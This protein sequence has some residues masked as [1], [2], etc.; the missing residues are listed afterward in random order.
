MVRWNEKKKKQYEVTHS[1]S[2]T[3]THRH[4]H[5][6]SQTRKMRVARAGEKRR[7]KGAHYLYDSYHTTANEMLSLKT[8]GIESESEPNH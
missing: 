2:H 1:H 7:K 8:S 5:T 4:T 6:N 3:Y